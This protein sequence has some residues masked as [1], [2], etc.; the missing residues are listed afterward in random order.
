[1]ITVIHTNLIRA[2]KYRD[3]MEFLNKRNAYAKD[4]TGVEARH[5]MQIGGQMGKVAVVENYP[6]LAD[7]EKAKQELYEDPGY[8]AILD[9]AT[10]VF[11]EGST[12]E[13]IFVDVKGM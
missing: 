13:L 4:K 3:A 8:T 12:E 11:V 7:L 2:G 5:Q 9:S 1:M 10:G 6:S